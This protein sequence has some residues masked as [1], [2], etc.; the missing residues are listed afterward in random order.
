MPSESLRVLPVQDAVKLTKK[1]VG[2]EP[3]EKVNLILNTMGDTADDTLLEVTDDR[4]LL[5]DKD[6]TTKYDWRRVTQHEPGKE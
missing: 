5:L 6:G 3:A 2:G 4:L 1:T